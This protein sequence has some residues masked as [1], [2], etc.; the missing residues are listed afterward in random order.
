M[1]THEWDQ[2][3]AALH[4]VARA[5]AEYHRGLRANGFGR[6]EAMTLTRDYQRVLLTGI[7]SGG[8]DG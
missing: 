3:Q 6:R 4:E 5:V 7:A 2:A 8:E 1:Q